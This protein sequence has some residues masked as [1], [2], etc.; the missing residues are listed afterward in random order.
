M[1]DLPLFT[2][3]YT[4]RAVRPFSV[5][6]L[7]ELLDRARSFN[8]R[9]EITGMLVHLAG[10]FMQALEGP[11]ESV[12]EL[13]SERILR[14]R[15][16]GLIEVVAKGPIRDR[17]FGDWTMAFKNLDL[18]KNRPE[19]FSEYLEKGFTTEL[20]SKNKAVA[21]AILN[22]F[23]RRFASLDDSWPPED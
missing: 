10:T 21:P 6:E 14:D 8:Q 1:N 18:V 3:I 11:K 9:H 15:R 4:S 16:H 19:G 17:K 20:A 2:L 12:N 23:K 5:D 7:N 22:S 13:F